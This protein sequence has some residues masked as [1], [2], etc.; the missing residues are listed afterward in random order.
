MSG[1]RVTVNLDPRATAAL[2]NLGERTGW[3]KT[4]LIN[5]GLRLLELAEALADAHGRLVV[6]ESDGTVHRIYLL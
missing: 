5:R 1:T 2:E 3:S 6:H 4:E